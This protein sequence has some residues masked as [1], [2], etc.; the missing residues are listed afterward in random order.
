M[1][2]RRGNLEMCC[3]KLTYT[4]GDHDVHERQL[5]KAKPP[6]LI[7]PVFDRGAVLD[8]GTLLVAAGRLALLQTKVLR[9][10]L[11]GAPEAQGLGAAGRV[12]HFVEGAAAGGI[13]GE[14]VGGLGCLAGFLC[15]AVHCSFLKLFSKIEKKQSVCFILNRCPPAQNSPIGLGSYRMS[16]SWPAAVAQLFRPAS[17]VSALGHKKRGV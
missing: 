13:V 6:P 10:I 1:K 7:R 12:G 5:S 16:H 3:L 2:K 8:I 11:L 15:D 14:H 17:S 9:R 4:P